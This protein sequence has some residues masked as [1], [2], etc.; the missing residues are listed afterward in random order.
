MIIKPCI[1]AAERVDL[2]K[3]L[4]MRHCL[5]LFSLILLGSGITSAQT[6]AD[7][8]ENTPYKNN[9]LEYGYYISNERVKEVKGEAFERYEVVLYVNNNSGCIKLIPFSNRV[10]GAEDETLVADFTVKNATG[11]R[12]TSK[13]GKIYARPW[14][15]QVK[16]DNGTKV[17]AQVGYAVR[18]GES[19]SNKI[20]V[21]VPQG[22][23]PK[24]NC[25]MLFLPE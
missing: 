25:R 19:I 21:I 15:T 16:L 12:L 9:G 3:Y 22:E 18:N 7:L 13:S 11:K 5:F 17:N 8:Q 6:V 14:F 23:R 2:L 10:V 24:I 4:V 1:S 20:I